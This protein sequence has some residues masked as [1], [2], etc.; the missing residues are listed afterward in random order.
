MITLIAS[1]IHLGSR[2]SQAAMF[3]HLLETDFDRLILNGD[4]I[5][6]I[7]FKK[8]KP[9]HWAVV[10][11]LQKVARHRE[12][13]LIRGNHDGAPGDVSGALDLLPKLIGV[14]F[15]EEY[16]LET[17]DRPYL[18]LHG[19]RFDPTLNW[20]VVTDAAEW[21]Y[22]TV[23]KFNKKSAKWLKRKVKHLGGVIEFVKQRSTRYAKELG[24][25]GVIAGHTHYCE[26]DWID[27]V[28]YVNTG[29]WVDST[30]TYLRATKS[31][32]RLCHWD[33]SEPRH[34]TEELVL[35]KTLPA[36]ASTL[37]VAGHA[38]R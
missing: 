5:N 36:P 21:C 38:A 32:L 25:A 29:C 14:P 6:S 7:N 18:I 22:H 30:C 20:P 23:Q 34:V 10:R 15:H 9:K 28:H 31:E 26:E 4:I 16:T 17:E 19:D 2:N 37:V 3:G 33:D 27:G 35:P 13:I 8:L 1:D 12:L 24:C 11:Q